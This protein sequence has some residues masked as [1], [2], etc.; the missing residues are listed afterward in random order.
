MGWYF[1]CFLPSGFT[2]EDMR[3]FC[4]RCGRTSCRSVIF[5]NNQSQSLL[6]VFKGQ[7]SATRL[8]RCDGKPGQTRANGKIKART[9]LRSESVLSQEILQSDVIQL[10]QWITEEL[11]GHGIMNR[12]GFQ[13]KLPWKNQQQQKTSA[14]FS[15]ELWYFKSLWVHGV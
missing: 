14:S 7:N 2:S 9:L 15:L 13:W 1:P 12:G 11:P 8:S 4:E 5:I 10:F 6:C 3:R